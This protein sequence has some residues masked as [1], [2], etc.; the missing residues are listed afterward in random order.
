L[1][2]FN[3]SKHETFREKKVKHNI[4]KKLQLILFLVFASTICSGQTAD[5][6]QKEEEEKVRFTTD[7][8]NSIYIPID[9]EDS[10]K[11]INTFWADSTKIKLKQLSEEEFSGRLHLGFGMWMRNNW[12]LWGGSRL[13][14]FF[15]DKGIFHPDDMS[16]IILDSYY[17]YLNNKEINFDEQI[18]YYKDYWQESKKAEI[19]IKKTEFTK[20]KISDTILFNYRKGFVSEAQEKKYDDDICIAKGIITELNPKDFF[21]KVKIIET[22][23][24]K[25]IL[26]GHNDGYISYNPK[27]KKWIDPKKYIKKGKQ[28]WFSYEDWE[29]KE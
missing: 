17:R 10:F 9:L 8:L 7:T 23:D 18:Q 26:Y 21:I 3:A 1:R 28:T 13:S 27:T 29:P 5:K 16:G 20:Y 19:E 2:F 12:Q 4:M 14:K 25:G 22:C 15:N 6:K 11:Q 24:K